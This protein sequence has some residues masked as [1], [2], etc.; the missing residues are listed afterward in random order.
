MKIIQKTSAEENGMEI[1]VEYDSATDNTYISMF[2]E[3]GEV[4]SSHD[5][6]PPPLDSS[7]I[8]D[9]PQIID[10]SSVGRKL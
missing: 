2:D 1:R 7:E 4:I 9:P 3:N 10:P 8:E 5:L 6:A